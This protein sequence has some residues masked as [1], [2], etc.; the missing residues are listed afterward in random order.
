MLNVNRAMDEFI[1]DYGDRQAVRKGILALLN[2]PD[3]LKIHPEAKEHKNAILR[4]IDENIQKQNERTNDLKMFAFLERV[5]N[6]IV[7]DK[8]SKLV[9][10]QNFLERSDVPADLKNKIAEAKDKMSENIVNAFGLLRQAAE[11]TNDGEFKTAI[12]S[13]LTLASKDPRDKDVTIFIFKDVNEESDIDFDKVEKFFEENKELIKLDKYI[14]EFEKLVSV[15]EKE[16]TKKR[17]VSDIS[18]R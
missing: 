10:L 16:Q 13:V 14:E 15:S 2:N 5:A 12:V 4:K 17:K 11:T 18:F 6:E 8:A 9:W 7:T 1:K 3:F